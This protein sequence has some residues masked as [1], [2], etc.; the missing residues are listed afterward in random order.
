M[1][2]IVA[3]VAS[4]GVALAVALALT[5]SG[6]TQRVL[7][8]TVGKYVTGQ[9]ISIGN[10]TTDPRG[11]QLT[12]RETTAFEGDPALI[13]PGIRVTVWYRGVA[14]RRLLVD[15]VRVLPVGVEP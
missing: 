1:R 10:E 14:E 2:T 8:G 13:K 7:T 5:N 12:L 6:S 9:L 11:V 15:R 4:L 3:F